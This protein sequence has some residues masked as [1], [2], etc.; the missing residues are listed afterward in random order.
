MCAGSMHWKSVKSIPFGFRL[1]LSF[2]LLA[3][4]F[5]IV[6]PEMGALD[7]DHDGMPETTITVLSRRAFVRLSSSLQVLQRKPAEAT[8]ALPF[9]LVSPIGPT[10]F[11]TADHHQSTAD[12]LPLYVLRC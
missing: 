11:I 6:G 10:R 3:V 5:F 12:A 7:L 4:V 2:G 8:V 9:V 1:V